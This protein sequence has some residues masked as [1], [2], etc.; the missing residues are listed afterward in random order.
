MVALDGAAAMCCACVLLEGGVLQ[1]CERTACMRPVVWEPPEVLS[2]A[3]QA[4]VK[5]IKRA[6]LFPFLRRKRRAL[7]SDAFQE[8]LAAL[9]QEGARGQPPVP[10]AKL[11]LVT[12]IQAYTGASDDEA[13]EALTMD[14]R[15]QLVLD[16]LDAE[17]APFGKGTLVRFRQALIAKDLDR[18]LIERTV[19]VATADEVHEL[20]PRH[21]RAALDSS[22]LWGAARVEDTYNLLGHALRK[23]I[24]VLARQQGRE[25]AAVAQEA[26]ADLVAGSSLKAALDLDWDAPEQQAQALVTILAA[27]TAVEE[28]AAAHSTS[29]Q[30]TVAAGLATARQIEAQDVAP[31]TDGR[32]ALIDGVAPDRRIAVEDADMRHGRKSKSLLVDGYKRHVLHDLDRKL[33]VAV[34]ITPANV[35]E[36]TVTAQ[37]VADLAHQP[38]HLTELDI[39]RA[40][41]SSALVRER[42]PDLQIACKAWPVRSGPDGHFPKTAFTLDWAAGT[43]HCPNA[44]SVPFQPGDTIQFPASSCS[45][46]PLRPRCTSS[47]HGRSVA[48]HPDERLLQE[49]RERQRTPAGRAKLRERVA[50]EHTLAHVGHWQGHRARYCGTRKNLFDLRRTAV[51]QNLHVLMARRDDTSPVTSITGPAL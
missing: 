11:A 22:P 25:L 3:E 39:D 2:V 29:D 12:I 48:I 18:R 1:E 36:A 31:G 47:R 51:V 24:G 6:K 20:S 10:P 23:V 8:E 34:G 9:Y 43:I 16:C 49:L 27:V 33:I 7:F 50:V 44:V 28:W 4:V 15:W 35:P 42:P 17:Q 19:E 30:E 26:G 40:Y 45:P 32:P 21:L 46:C 41:L 38:F 5:R 37:I 14:R 13:I